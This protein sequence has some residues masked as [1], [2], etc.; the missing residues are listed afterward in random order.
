MVTIQKAISADPRNPAAYVQLALIHSA[1]GDD[2][3]ARM[4]VEEAL[5][6]DPNYAPAH[7]QRASQL[8]RAKDFEGAIREAKLALSLKP[9]P[10]FEAYAH[11]TLG[12]TYEELK[13]YDE[14]LNEY[15]EAIRSNPADGS[16]HGTLGSALFSLKRY[17]EAENAFRRAVEIDPQDSYA[18][19]NLAAALHNQ[20]KRDE[21]IKYYKEYLRLE[22]KAS[23]RAAIEQRISQLERTPEPLLRNQ[24]LLVM[25]QEGDAANAA[26]LI[27]SGADPNYKSSYRLSN[28]SERGRPKGNLEVVKLLLTRG[29]KD[30]DGAALTNAYEAGK[31]D[32]EKLLQQAAPAYTEGP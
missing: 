4:A 16:L 24:M 29:A 21:S 3:K 22:P 7:Q 2:N 18:V 14:A 9:D 31:A 13:R 28:S 10:E 12:R 32:I 30:D 6:I 1:M 17:D 11:L 15:R 26:A 25:A 5:K 19:V 20:A 23:D 8:R 27:T